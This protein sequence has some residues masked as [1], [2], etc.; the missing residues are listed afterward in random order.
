VKNSAFR[1]I[2][3]E[4]GVARQ[5][6]SKLRRDRSS[7]ELAVIPVGQMMTILTG[8]GVES[9]VEKEDY[10]QG[11]RSQASVCAKAHSLSPHDTYVAELKK[12]GLLEWRE[13][14]LANS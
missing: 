12:K 9:R 5:S 3:E 8:F 6:N 14:N 2:S 1:L 13:L 11:L 10:L 7:D 4:V